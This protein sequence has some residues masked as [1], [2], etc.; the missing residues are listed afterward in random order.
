MRLCFILIGFFIHASFSWA[1]GD[2]VRVINF[3]STQPTSSKLGARLLE[4]IDD[5]QSE[6]LPSIAEKVEGDGQRLVLITSPVQNTGGYV[7]K[8]ATRGKR[9]T[10]CLQRPS[11]D[12]IVSQSLTM[13]AALALLPPGYTFDN[14]VG[15]CDER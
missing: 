1:N 10:F 2:D 6:N 9:V 11:F 4:S 7:F 12:S 13:P 5:L 14:K 15:F 8:A 3:N